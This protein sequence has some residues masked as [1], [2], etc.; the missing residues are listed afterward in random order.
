MTCTYH[1]KNSFFW[2]FL[3]NLS[4]QKLHE[5]KLTPTGDAWFWP[6]GVVTSSGLSA[7]HGIVVEVPVV[8]LQD[9]EVL[10]TLV[11]EWKVNETWHSV[12]VSANR[13]LRVRPVRD[14]VQG[15]VLLE[16]ETVYRGEDLPL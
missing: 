10:P 15:Q 3:K 4:D 2:L 1:C 16:K 7:G 11:T 8:P 9:G 12:L 5:I 13:P 6:E 14:A